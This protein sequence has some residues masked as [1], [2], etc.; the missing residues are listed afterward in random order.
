[1]Y[2]LDR[3]VRPVY[4][5]FHLALA[6]VAA[7]V[8]LS[9]GRSW[10]GLD[11]L[12]AALPY[13]PVSL[14]PHKNDQDWSLSLIFP[15]YQRLTSLKPS[16]GQVDPSLALTWRISDDGLAYTFVIKQDRTFTDGK[17]LDA[18]AVAK[19]FQR[20]MQPGYL[21]S[22]YFPTLQKIQL[23][24]PF[25]VR[26]H[27]SRPTPFFLQALATGAGSIVSP[28]V[29][30]HVAGYLDKNTAGS[31]LYFLDSWQAG[32]QL[33][34]KARDTSPSGPPIGRFVA[35]FEASS[36]KQLTLLQ[37][38]RVHVAAGLGPADLEALKYQEPLTAYRVTTPAI[39]FMAMNCRRPW[40]DQPAARQALAGAMD[41]QGLVDLSW[42][43]DAVSA[44][45]PLP[46]GMWGGFSENISVAYNP[47]LVENKLNEVGLPPAPLS[48]VYRQGQEWQTHEARLIK[49]YLEV[50][51]IQ[52]KLEPETDDGYDQRARNGDF[53]LF[54]GVRQ[55]LVPH[56]YPLLESW[57]SPTPA[58]GPD[59]NLARYRNSEVVALLEK[60]SRAIDQK[61]A[62]PLYHRLQEIVAQEAPYLYLHQFVRQYGA[63]PG[64]QGFMPTPAQPYLIPLSTMKLT[65]GDVSPH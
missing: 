27:L 22:T 65:H 6:L 46:D 19:S 12:V 11:S 59:S 31:G 32:T 24:G 20:A 53:D 56:P 37:T 23:L 8:V 55:P 2:R 45:G 44:V 10:A 1:M 33:V 35:I 49:T 38:G 62:L 48:L 16:D 5:V 64:L 60:I 26:F 9:A 52:V 36:D 41:Y 61:A 3:R 25:T 51:R 28:G 54:L 14:D 39:C 30:E 13:E 58:P 63:A 4:R 50:F 7:L 40:L 21:G 17:I 47:G 29:M 15:C 42:A 34:L 43:G 57:F 18:I